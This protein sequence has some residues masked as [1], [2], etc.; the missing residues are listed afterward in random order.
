ME[1]ITTTFGE[2]EF[3]SKVFKDVTLSISKL[4]LTAIKRYSVLFPLLLFHLDTY[5]V[6]EVIINRNFVIRVNSYIHSKYGA[7]LTFKEVAEPRRRSY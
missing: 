1:F 3:S 2:K 6:T 5:N 7:V 4:N